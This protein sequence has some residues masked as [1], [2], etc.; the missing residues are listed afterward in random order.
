MIA[1]KKVYII[2]LIESNIVIELYYTGYFE[3]TEFQEILLT[4]F[5]I[6]SFDE[7]RIL[8]TAGINLTIQ[9]NKDQDAKQAPRKNTINYLYFL[10]QIEKYLSFQ[11]PER[12]LKN[13][14]R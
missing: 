3:E 5:P 9:D 10:V 7:L 12:F 14:K 6:L 4:Y 8:T 1:T 11:H 13:E 2:I